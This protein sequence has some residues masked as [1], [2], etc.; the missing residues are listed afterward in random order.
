LKEYSKLI[1][2][3]EESRTL[4][5]TAMI[6]KLK[7][8]GKDVL[9]FSAGEPDFPTPEFIKKAA[10]EAIN[11]NFTTYT[12]NEGYPGL[13]NAIIDKLKRENG[14]E[15]EA[16]NI[17]VSNGVKHSLYNLLFS[18]CNPGD[19][20]VYQSPY[21]VSYPEMVKLCGAKSVVIDAG[22]EQEY[23][24]S[25]E[26]LEKALTEKT[27]VFIFNTPSNPTGAVYSESEIREIGEVLLDKPDII[28]IS[29]EIYERI[30]FDGEKHFCIAAIPGLKERTITVNGVSKSFAMTGWRI[31]Y[32]AG[33]DRLIRLARNLQSHSTSNAASISQAA[34]K[35]A[36][37]EETDEIDKMVSRFTERRDYIV[38]ELNKISNLKC[39]TPKGAFYVFFDV[40]GYYGR[41]VNGVTIN[42]S[43]GFCNY[44]LQDVQV[45]LVPGIAFGNDNCVRMSY[46]CSESDL[47]DGVERIK[48]SLSSLT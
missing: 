29:D 6:K 4:S 34:A 36:L 47:R 21:W 46:A 48:K 25:A 39:P 40:S 42:D 8:D 43:T 15:Y 17:L 33:D 2:S 32:A 10:I 22:V 31:G 41:S 38:A 14:L 20:V 45:G 26:Q 13:I 5:I 27:R 7:A 28:I 30:I 18:I 12:A 24:I 23:K 11:N 9:S 1:S 3:I 35:A 16:K 19:E 37:T 44:L